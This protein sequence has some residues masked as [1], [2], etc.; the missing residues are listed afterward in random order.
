MGAINSYRTKMEQCQKEL[1]EQYAFMKTRLHGKV[2]DSLRQW[3]KSA[4]VWVINA[5]T[6]HQPS[7]EDF[8]AQRKEP[9]PVERR[10]D[11]AQLIKFGITSFGEAVCEFKLLKFAWRD[12]IQVDIENIR[13]IIKLTFTAI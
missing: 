4:G 6:F 10:Y 13:G 7:L 9:R 2:P 8:L 12:D 3:S 5:L 11:A 1:E